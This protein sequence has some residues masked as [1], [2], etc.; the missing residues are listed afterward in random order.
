M[1]VRLLHLERSFARRALPPVSERDTVSDLELETLVQAMAAGD[2]IIAGVARE[3][4]LASCND[5]ETIRY[6]QAILADSVA[7]APAVRAM[8]GLAVETVNAERRS[9]LFARL[10][11]TPGSVLFRAI[12]LME[13]LEV[14]L[15]RL[16]AIVD[17]HAAEFASAGFRGLATMI[18]SEMSAEYF[19]AI[20]R[21]LQQLRFRDGVLL[22]AR[23]G[24]GNKGTGYA[25]RL[26]PPTRFGWIPSALRGRC[27][28]SHSF[29][30]PDQDE[31]GAR[32]IAG[33]IDRGKALVANALGQSADHVLAFFTMLRDELAFYVGSLNLHNA[34]TA[35]EEPTC[36]PHPV[37][38]DERVRSA[39]GLYDP[40]LALKAGRAVVGN[41]LNADGKRLVVVTGANRG[42]KSTFLRSVGVAQL[43]MQCGMFVAARRFDA[44]LCEHLFTHYKRE[45]DATMLSGKLDEEL[46]R[47]SAIVDRLTPKSLV[48]LNESFGSTNEK[49]GAEIARQVVDA[50][51]QGGI[52][53]YFVTHQYEFANALTLAG[54]ADVLFLLAE[55]RDDGGRTFKI[56][57]GRPL[58]TSYGRDLYDL[59][60]GETTAETGGS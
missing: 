36:I 9:F 10:G 23:L 57:P 40:C 46:A 35:L 18:Q 15:C 31:G 2:D 26:A 21:H 4:L 38:S 60:F 34:L 11:R 32:A 20:R 56:V 54:R 5:I 55:R 45:E 6:R 33:L 16:R 44:S 58:P 1:Q 37:A 13:M 29:R 8:Y 52:T 51:I 19:E 42:G 27:A 25:L 3:V 7:N 14:R 41:D 53:V 24:R 49:E 22:S 50:L 12:E 30:I 47:M 17:E 59:V 28:D 39:E 48:L 43:M